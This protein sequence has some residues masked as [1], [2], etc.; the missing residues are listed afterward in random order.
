VSDALIQL[1]HVSKQYLLG[2]ERSNLRAAL[3]GRFGDPPRDGTFDA[4]HDVSLRIE[5]GEAVGIIGANG[6]GKSTVL[7]VLAGIVRPSRGRVVV[8]D[9]VVSVIELGLGFDPDLSGLENLLYGGALLGLSAEEVHAKAHDII[10]FAELEE[11]MHMPVKRYS[12]GM[13]A[14]LGFALATSVE[15]EVYIVDE[16]LSVGDWG[17]QRRSLD[18]MRELHAAG[19]TIV[20]VSHD[21]WLVEQLCDRAVLMDKGA[22]ASSGPTGEVIAAYLGG[23]VHHLAAEH[24]L[25]DGDGSGDPDP[26]DAAGPPGRDAPYLLRDLRAEP[27]EIVPGDAVDLVGTI[28]VRRA[29][30]GTRLAVSGYWTGF[31]A[32]A[33]PDVLDSEL[34]QRPGHHTFRIRYPVMPLAPSTATFRVAVISRDDPYDPEQVYPHALADA[35]TELV[36]RGSATPRPGLQL[37]RTFE[38]ESHPGEDPAAG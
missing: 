17:F 8:P 3:P 27:G 16:V 38:V 24:R 4:L 10:A 7:K 11:F 13:M 5:R 37:P 23:D 2:R 26:A 6:A 25:R 35:S 20:F 22:V 31:A 29:V 33:D 1:E 12:S 30:P 18:R 15:S 9:G 34:L 36:I 21:L 32:F 19:A 28:E 14:R